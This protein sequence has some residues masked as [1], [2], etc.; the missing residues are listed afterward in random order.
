MFSIR[1][2][3]T[4]DYRGVCLPLQLG[5]HCAS[6][7][8][9]GAPHKARHHSLRPCRVIAKWEGAR[10]GGEEEGE[11]GEHWEQ[12]HREAARAGVRNR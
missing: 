2:Y 1:P 5:G 7:E 6:D 3:F 10:V 4:E 11:T 9:G 12:R 8:G